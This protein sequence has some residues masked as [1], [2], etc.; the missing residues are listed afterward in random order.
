MSATGAGPCGEI[1]VLL[2]AILW[3][4]GAMSSKGIQGNGRDA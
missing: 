2:T 1:A 4:A 3:G